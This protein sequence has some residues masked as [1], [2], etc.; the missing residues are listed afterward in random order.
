[1]ENMEKNET[2]QQSE[3]VNQ[4]SDQQEALFTQEQVNEIIR[5]RLSKQKAET[6]DFTEREASLSAREKRMDCREYLTD[7]GYPVELLE[8]ID[9]SDVDEFKKRAD[10]AYRLTGRSQVEYV[11]P[12][13]SLERVSGDAESI[14][15]VFGTPGKHKPKKFPPVY[16]D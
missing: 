1:M 13:A 5:K 2:L 6:R 7:Q 16:E 11:A 12:L 9:T 15:T 4:A 10:M 14:K 3:E 8:I